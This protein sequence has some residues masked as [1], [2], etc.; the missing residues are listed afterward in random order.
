MTIGE[1]VESISHL[2]PYLHIMRCSISPSVVTSATSEESQNGQAD[3]G[4]S[5]RFGSISSQSLSL[6]LHSNPVV[7][8]YEP[9]QKA[10]CQEPL[11][12]Q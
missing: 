5:M 2:C 11:L 10:I 9:S 4:R 6:R 12:T 1:P 7:C 3:A 8:Q